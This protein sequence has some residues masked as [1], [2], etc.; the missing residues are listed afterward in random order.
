LGTFHHDPDHGDA[1]IDA[2][3]RLCRKVLRERR[4][5]AS[6]FGAAEGLEIRL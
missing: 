6:C 2:S 4:S 5:R 1:Q 3:I